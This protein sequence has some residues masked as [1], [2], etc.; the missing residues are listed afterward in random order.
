[1]GIN[2]ETALARPSTVAVKEHIESAPNKIQ[3]WLK[4]FTRQRKYC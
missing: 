2:S 3:D 4:P 1:M